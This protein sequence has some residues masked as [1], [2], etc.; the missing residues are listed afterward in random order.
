[1][2]TVGRKRRGEE[3][4]KRD[5]REGREKGRGFFGKV[6][7]TRGGREKTNWKG[8]GRERREEVKEQKEECAEKVDE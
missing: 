1:M 5:R 4:R 3:R 8:K 6:W 7:G 2:G